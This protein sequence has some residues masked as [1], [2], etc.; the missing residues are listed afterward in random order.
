[1]SFIRLILDENWESNRSTGMMKLL[2]GSCLTHEG[3]IVNEKIKQF[4]TQ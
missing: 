3:A 1:M 2:K 4:Y